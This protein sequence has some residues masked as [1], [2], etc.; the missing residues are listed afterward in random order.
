MR[1]VEN[2]GKNAIL[3]TCSVWNVLSSDVLYGAARR[4]KMT[5]AT[6]P[7]VLYE[8]LKKQRT[9][10]LTAEHVELRRRLQSRRDQGDFVPV[11]LSIDD[12]QQVAILEA[13][14]KLGA[15]ELSSI[16]IAHRVATLAFQTDDGK[17]RRL[18]EAV[19]PASRVQTTPQLLGWLCFEGHLSDGDIPRL[20]EEHEAMRHPSL[21]PYFEA[22]YK[23]ALRCRLMTRAQGEGPIGHPQVEL[24]REGSVHDDWDEG[25]E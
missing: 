18:A 19:L 1:S 14:K 22:M 25:H 6:T 8:C 11:P 15:G 2:I 21:R 12:L 7:F 16:A 24:D 5:F 20:V 13:R 17:A 3:D 4:A 10:P 23:E 9:S